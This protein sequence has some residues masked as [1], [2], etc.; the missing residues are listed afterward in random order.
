ME[1]APRPL[2]PS[3][4]AAAA[5]TTTTTTTHAPAAAPAALWALAAALTA[6]RAAW[7]A[8]TDLSPDEAYYWTWAVHGA[9]ADHPPGV[10]WLIRAGVALLGPTELG[11]RAGAVACGILTLLAMH[12]LACHALDHAPEAARWALGAAAAG[13]LMPLGA[14]GAVIHTP[15]S[16]L[17]AAWCLALLGLCRAE[18]AATTP[19]AAV[20]S[21]YLAGAATAAGLWFKLTMGLFPLVAL[22]TLLSSPA[23]R[24]HLR[25]PHPYL[26]LVPALAS[27]AALAARAA[28]ANP[29]V[30]QIARAA[31]RPGGVRALA[32]LAAAQLGVVTP[33]LAAGGA[34]F[35]AARPWR[36]RALWWSAVVPLGFFAALALFTRPEASWPGVAW[37]G[38]V[39]G[40]AAWAYHAQARLPWMRR[41]ALAALALAGAAGAV[42]H[43]QALWPIVPLPTSADPTERLSGWRALGAAWTA[44]R[45]ADPALPACAEHWGLAAALEFYDL[46]AHRPVCT[47]GAGATTD[48]ARWGRRAPTFWPTGT[49]TAAGAIPAVPHAAERLVAAAAPACADPAPARLAG[50]RPPRP[51]RAIIVSRCGA[52]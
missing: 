26:A 27:A 14:A 6:L 29:F 12:R 16:A 9:H 52:P 18:A 23:G 44:R 39:P 20:A 19:R 28:G 49:T 25:T 46:P 51:P 4:S 42:A 32:E 17:A 22:G 43:V 15:D 45:D 47:L 5:T 24:R 34:A 30:F 50:A 38:A 10:G 36:G 40:A 21:L 48:S 31:E 2:T 11:V 13:A 35:I 3:R 41:T 8:A 1:A 37:A 7:A 33:L